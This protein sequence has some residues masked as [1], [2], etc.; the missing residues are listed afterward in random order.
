MAKNVKGTGKWAGKNVPGMY[1]D[2]GSLKKAQGG[3]PL[4]VD[5]RIEEYQAKSDSIRSSLS[6][7]NLANYTGN[8]NMLSRTEG[9]QVNVPGLTNEQ[10]DEIDP[11]FREDE[12]GQIDPLNM[13]DEQMS[14][15]DEQGMGNIYNTSSPKIA[16]YRE[17]TG[18]DSD[19]KNWQGQSD[20]INEMMQSG[21]SEE[22]AKKMINWKKKGGGI[23]NYKKKKGGFVKGIGSWSNRNIPGMRYD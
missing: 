14:I 18:Y 21:M 6:P 3:G 10:I 5:P 12:M 4:F 22:D 20:K 19:I 2:G 15:F 1:K 8:P 7:E 17:M 11:F 13:T 9:N 23:R 16:S